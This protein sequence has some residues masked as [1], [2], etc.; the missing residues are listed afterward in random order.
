MKKLVGID[1]AVGGD[2]AHISAEL[3]IEASN[4]KLELSATMPI[5]KVIDPVMKA[6]DALVDKFEQWIPGDQKA[7]AEKVKAEFRADAIKYLS[8]A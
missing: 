5:A 3:G 2:G 7:F 1:Q 4:L 6:A 8:E